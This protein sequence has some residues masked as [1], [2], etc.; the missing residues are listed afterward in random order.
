M[1]EVIA[2]VIFIWG[3]SCFRPGIER[4]RNIDAFVLG[5][6][7]FVAG[8]VL[9][10]FTNFMTMGE[11]WLEKGLLSFEMFENF[12]YFTGSALFLVGTILYW[13][14]P[15]H[16]FWLISQSTRPFS[17]ENNKFD[18]EF[19]G[20]LLFAI[21]SVL[22]AAGA[23]TNA[24]NKRTFTGMAAALHGA[25]TSLYFGGSLLFAMGCIAFLPHLG[26]GSQMLAV[27]AWTFVVGSV[28][29]LVGSVMSLVHTWYFW[30]NGSG[31]PPCVDMGGS[32]K[33]EAPF[34][35]SSCGVAKQEAAAVSV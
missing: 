25:I 7:L 24:L 8:S 13:P 26:C 14:E 23:F 12:L 11:A 9:F 19:N 1:T 34:I 22:F 17:C 18:N 30:G 6:Q 2:A 35:C 10:M 20:T 16:R 31:T 29:F 15:E 4:D 33:M 21:G 5:C 28:F 32:E 27:G 3:S